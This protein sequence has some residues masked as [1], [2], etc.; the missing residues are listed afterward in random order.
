[1]VRRDQ[2]EHTLRGRIVYPMVVQVGPLRWD[3]TEVVSQ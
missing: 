2:V 3:S 1:M